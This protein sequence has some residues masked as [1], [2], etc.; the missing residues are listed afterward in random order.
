MTTETSG[1]YECHCH[2]AL[3]GVDF[4]NA[5]VRHRNGPDENW[6]RGVLDAYRKAGIRY[7]RDGGDKWGA[8][9]LA[10][11][12]AGEY[13][14]EYASPVF[15]IYRRGDYGA[16]I[17]VPYETAADLRSLISRVLAEGG[18]FVKMMGSGIMDFDRFGVI[19]GFVPAQEELNELVRTAHGE[20]LPVMMHMNSADGIK[21]AVDAGADSVEHGNYAD[22]EA[23]AM[24]ADAG[25]LWVPTVSAT[26]NLMGRGLFDEK[27]LGRILEMQQE[28]IRLG[29]SLGVTIACGSDAG[30]SCVRHAEAS[31][32]E[33]ERLSELLGGWEPVRAGQERVRSVF[34]G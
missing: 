15:P 27:A 8:S 31:L 33:A 9:A 22:R 13:G 6:V 18:C 5:R 11:R 23:L 24:M 16:F 17:G 25:C 34:P 10:R 26:V 20:G 14:I 4:R 2:V 7:V 1:V 29:H 12:L 30:A 3:D 32:Q 28:G 21:R 19:T